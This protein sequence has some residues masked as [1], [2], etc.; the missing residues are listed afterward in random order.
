VFTGIVTELG[1]VES[2]DAAAGGARLVLRA[3][4]TAAEA[5]VGDSVAI[6]GCCLTVT[7]RERELLHFEAIPETLRR[8]SLGDLSAGDRVNL[9]LPLRVGD[10]MGGHWVQGHVDGVGT[11]VSVEADGDAVDVTVSAPTDVLRYTI[12]KGSICMA[13]TSLT[14]TA[15]DAETFTV[16]LIPHTREATNLGAL[17]PG[18]RVNLEADMVGKYVERLTAVGRLPA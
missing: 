12:L 16:S 6:D 9:E 17:A 1:A 18:R 13:G 2:I 15:V 11:V 4:R 3:P 5:E 14:V 10:R 7:L 8:T